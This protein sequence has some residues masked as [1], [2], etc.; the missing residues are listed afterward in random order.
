M[1][2]RSS[3]STAPATRSPARVSTPIGERAP[4]WA[5]P[6]VG[7]MLPGSTRTNRRERP[8]RRAPWGPAVMAGPHFEAISSMEKRPLSALRYE[9]IQE[10]G[11]SPRLI[12]LHDHDQAGDAVA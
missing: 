2:R 6:L 11:G 12:T 7:G 5:M 3:V 8:S 10:T 4:R 1:E 9:R